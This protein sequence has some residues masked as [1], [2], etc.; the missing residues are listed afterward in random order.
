MHGH[1]SSSLVSRRGRV[2]PPGHRDRVADR[3]RR[4]VAR[5]LDL[6]A[7]PPGPARRRGRRTPCRGRR[8]PRRDPP[9]RR[10]PRPPR[11]AAA[12]PPAAARA[13]PGRCRLA[14]RRTVT[15]RLA[16]AHRRA[17]RVARHDL[18]GHDVRVA[19]EAR[20]ERRG[21]RVVDVLGRA[22][23]LHAALVEDRDA[24]REGERLALVVRDVDERRAR[25]A[26]HAPQ[27]DLHLQADLEV[28]R[29]QRLVQQQHLRPVDE[30]PRQRD[31][32]HL[33]ARELV[34]AA[35]LVAVQAHQPQRLGHARR[36]LALRHP[37]DAQPEADVALHV[38]VREQ[39]RALED[40]V[41]RALVRR[42][43][44]DV[45]PA[46]HDAPRGRPHEAGDGPQQRRLA[47][48]RRARAASRTRRPGSPG[49]RRRAPSPG[50]SGGSRRRRAPGRRRAPSLMPPPPPC[51]RPRPPARPARRRSCAARP[52]R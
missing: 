11:A 28:E 44:R 26:V 14:P 48:A 22:E 45:A 23:L 27:L 16:D 39:R 8:G 24:V 52:A 47:A 29:R 7:A 5:R 19:H 36:G 32:L 30:R 49:R 34:R 40:H 12:A 21:G 3:Q 10:W 17:G 13:T 6:D 38:E 31:A 1:A 20:G 2:R 37:G 46:D 18:H 41:D 50:R 15:S 51:A 4:A 42:L 35:A 9:S 25:L 43:A 33:A